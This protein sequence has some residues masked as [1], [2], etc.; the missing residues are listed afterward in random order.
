MLKRVLAVVGAALAVAP[1]AFAGGP[2][3]TIGATEDIVKQ[4]DLVAAKAQMDLLKLAG[5]RGVR[6]TQEWAPGQTEPGGADF[7]ALKNA[8]TAAQLNGVR[9]ILSVTNHGSRTTPLS[10]QDQ[11]DFATYAANV[12][13][14]LP[15]IRDYVIGN[16]P[17]LN[18][19]WLPQFGL[20]GSDVA[21]PAYESL[22]AR[23]YDA[24]KAVSPKITVLGGA[25][26]PRGID[27]PNTG[28]DTHSP[29]AF[30]TDMGAAYKASGRTKP[31]MDGFAFHP[32]GD[33]SSQPPDTPHPNS[34][35][36]GLGDYGKL[37]ALLGAAFDGTAQP[38][39]TL[40]IVYDEY[41]VETQIPA[42]KTSF[43][44]GR[45]PTTTKPVDP[46]TQ[47]AY[48]A[49]AIALTFCQPNV[50]G[51]FLFHSVDE[52]DL[53]RWQSGLY[54]ADGTPKTSLGP[55][56]TAIAAAKRGIVAR[57]AGLRLPVKAKLDRPSAKNPRFSFR[58]SCDIDC[59]Y[60]ARLERL[61]Q[62]STVMVKRGVA[63]GGK[64]LRVAFPARE[65]APGRY[66]F[67]VRLAASVNPGPSRSLFSAAF[68]I[69]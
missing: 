52:T 50:R 64:P 58:L 30:I 21:A 15:Y 68:R 60:R 41:G 20:D 29:T 62:H 47:G 48:Y 23:T 59:T 2:T 16:E 40:P 54:Y 11:S 9:V 3:M 49:Q 57:C 44:S 22:L 1:A 31:I 18:R 67:T 55:T 53:D 6:I 5:L 13:R 24:L 36:I 25:V 27:R 69:L 32:Y 37:V 38:G 66:R 65:L 7:D 10:D 14:A 33:N 8:V 45:E 26:S 34:T 39:S 4:P 12:A 35:S 56:R 28:R 17:N 42:A 61:P 43:Y 46:T 51:L 63:V 19:Y